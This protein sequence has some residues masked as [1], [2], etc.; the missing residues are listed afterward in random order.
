MKNSDGKTGIRMKGLRRSAWGRAAGACGV[1]V[2]L[3]GCSLFGWETPAV[4]SAA[5]RVSGPESQR[6]RDHAKLVAAFGGEIQ[7]PAVQRLLADLTNRLVAASDRPDE[8]YRVTVLNSPVVNAFALPTGRLYVTR[9]LLALANDTAEVAAVLSHEIAHVTLRHASLRSE[10]EARSALIS[11][12][13]QNVLKNPTEAAIVQDSSRFTLASFSRSQELEADQAGVKVLARAGF[14]PFGAPR[15]LTALGKSGGGA[16]QSRPTLSDMLSTHPTTVERI[17]LALQAARRASAPGIGENDRSGYLAA[18]DGLAYGEDPGDGLIRGRTFVH[19]RLGVAFEAP[20]GISLENNAEAVLGASADGS[21]RLLFDAASTPDGQSLEDVLR[22]TWNDTIDPGS[23]EAGTVNGLPVATASSRGKEWWFR[24]SAV[25]I[26]RTTF[27]LIVA[28][29]AGTGDIEHM[30]RTALASVRQVT[31]AEA[32]RLAP[33][34]LQIVTAQE[35]ETAEHMGARM[36]VDRG[37]ERFLL[38]NGIERAGPLEP[39]ARYKIV[40][41]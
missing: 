30:F 3:S 35:G 22:T 8:S 41:E 36:A 15:F 18:I 40:V 12:V 5:P 10:L 33:L 23:L 24:L 19:G 21:R 1:L 9:G 20:E 2:L 7:S 17:S 25:R 6:D 29:R 13:T 37:L 27:R 11:K 26:G 38:L 4:P 14:D 31:P 39:G 28:T 32:R 16:D 34:R